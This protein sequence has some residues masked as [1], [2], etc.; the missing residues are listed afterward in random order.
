MSRQTLHNRISSLGEL[1]VDVPKTKTPVKEIHIFA[2]E[3][4][5]GV[6]TAGGK[7]NVMVPLIAITEGID[8]SNPKRHKVK[9]PLYSRI[10]AISKCDLQ[11]GVR[12]GRPQI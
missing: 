7:K 4:H 1:V 5:V 6:K 10:Q 9:N 2:D 3:D 12:D 8:G 11:S